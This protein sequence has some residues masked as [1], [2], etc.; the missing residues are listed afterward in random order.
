VLNRL[1]SYCIITLCEPKEGETMSE[2]DSKN[3]SHL[4]PYDISLE[5]KM[6]IYDKQPYKKDID[7]C[8]SD[9]IKLVSGNVVKFYSQNY[10]MDDPYTISNRDSE[11]QIRLQKEREKFSMINDAP[12][13]LD[14]EA[15]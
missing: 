15:E 3:S 13:V 1:N 8:G 10:K 11:T 7:L 5:D 12:D 14:E 6:T 2:L 9:K 4:R